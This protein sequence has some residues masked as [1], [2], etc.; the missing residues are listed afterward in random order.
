MELSSKFEG[1]SAGCPAASAEP[2]QQQHLEAAA[3]DECRAGS[4]AYF[5]VSSRK[6]AQPAGALKPCSPITLQ[7]GQRGRR[8]AS[9]HHRSIP[10]KQAAGA[11]K[12]TAA[13][14]CQC[15]RP[16]SWQHSPQQSGAGAVL[17]LPP[18]A[19][20]PHAGGLLKHGAGSRPVARAVRCKAC[21]Q[22][23]PACLA[24]CQTRHGAKEQYA[25]MQRQPPPPQHSWCW[26][27]PASFLP[28][29]TA[30]PLL[31]APAAAHT[32]ARA[33]PD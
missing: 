27:A 7:E 4:A 11:E 24:P 26:P 18:P 23:N 16:A 22:Y 5:S 1:C 31:P 9:Q 33:A 21:R 20:P 12:R 6:P 29:T 25:G 14:A 30:P 8:Q 13:Q 10:Q 15:Q 28:A 2:L 17:H 32:A 19:V 3:W